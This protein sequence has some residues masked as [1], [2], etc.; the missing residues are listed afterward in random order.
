MPGARRSPTGSRSGR[1]PT[2]TRWPA[3]W[4]ARFGRTVAEQALDG[5]AGPHV[6][7][8]HAGHAG[9][10]SPGRRSRSIRPPTTTP[11][12]GPGQARPPGDVATGFF[13]LRRDRVS[14]SGRCRAEFPAASPG[15]GG[16]RSWTPARVRQRNAIADHDGARTPLLG[17]S[18]SLTGRGGR[19]GRQHGLLGP[20]RRRAASTAARGT[21]SL[22]GTVTT[23]MLGADYA[24]GKWLVGLALAQSEGEGDY[25]DTGIDPRPCLADLSRRR[26]GSVR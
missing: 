11:D 8:P 7:G 3:A 26:G 22:D 23:G 21:F 15:P 10:R 17:S 20:G 14:R 4:L 12:R 9:A 18:F 19:L 2:T 5:I 24:R 16:P 25:R 1:S 6:G 13:G